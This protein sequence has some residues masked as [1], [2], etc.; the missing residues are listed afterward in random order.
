MNIKI[1]ILED[2]KR[3]FNYLSELIRQWGEKTGNLIKIDF[4]T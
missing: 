4:Q 3:D 1:T 2:N